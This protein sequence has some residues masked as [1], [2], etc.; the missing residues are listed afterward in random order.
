MY[1]HTPDVVDLIS[2]YSQKLLVYFDF[3]QTYR[4]QQQQQQHYEEINK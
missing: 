3:I 2:I 1:V 4:Q